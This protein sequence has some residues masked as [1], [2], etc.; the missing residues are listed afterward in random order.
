M[1]GYYKNEKA[2][3]STFTDDGYIKSGDLGTIDKKGFLTIT[4]RKKELIITAGGENVAPIPIEDVF[5]SLCPAC[6]NIIVVGENK[7]FISALISFKV[8]MDM[9]TR[10]PSKNL[11]TEATNEL[12][13]KCGEAL[14]TTDEAC[15]NEK[16]KMYIE[17]IINETNKKA[18]S[19]SA[20]LK[21]FTL[22]P[23]DFSIAGGELTPTTK[24]K[25]RVTETKY[26]E[27]ID[28]MYGEK[29]EEPKQ[30][31]NDEDEDEEM[32]GLDEQNDGEGS[33]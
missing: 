31:E 17:S 22:I 12:K 21:K 3:V 33:H 18:I 19:R 27:T 7:K 2:C 6:S 11:T 13:E 28:V 25:R 29:K 26:R 10:T 8:D 24:L 1:M 15:N 30:Q 23:M 14:K 32:P 9:K 16:V 5:K 4:G 20:T